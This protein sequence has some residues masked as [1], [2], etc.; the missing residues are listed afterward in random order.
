MYKNPVNQ[1]R[2]SQPK[3]LA[4]LQKGGG[5]LNENRGVRERGE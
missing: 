3:V 4:V 5:E 1:N 2:N